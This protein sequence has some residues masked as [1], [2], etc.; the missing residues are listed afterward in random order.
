MNKG[1]FGAALGAT[2]VCAPLAASAAVVNVSGSVTGCTNS[3]LCGGAHLG[4][5]AYVG[6]LIN[7]VQ[8]VFGPGAYTVTN[9]NGMMG[10]NPFF[11]AWNFNLG[12]ETNW[13][14]A[15]MII[16]DATKTVVLDSLP[17]PN[18]FVGSQAAVSSAAYALNYSG[19]F[20]LDSTRT[21]DFITEDY[22][23]YDNAGG[24]A[25]NIQLQG[26]ETTSGGV[27]EPA[28]WA[29]MILGFSAVGL[30]ARR[31]RHLLRAV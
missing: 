18:A 19:A 23:P 15:F 1:L 27:P 8:M 20:T 31:R 30:T 26:G 3:S 24:V 29:M 7:P 11:T 21:L 16:D 17:D 28:T 5:G 2:L 14:W 4:P 10:A 25:L 22:Y 13:I 9:A 12:S 6:D